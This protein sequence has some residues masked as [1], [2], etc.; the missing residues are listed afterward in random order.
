VL[1]GWVRYSDVS[2]HIS[3][4]KQQIYYMI[5]PE[6]MYY[7]QNFLAIGQ[8]MLVLNQIEKYPYVSVDSFDIGPCL[9]LLGQYFMRQCLI[10]W[11]G[12]LIY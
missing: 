3:L 4:V 11:V 1:Y 8:H 2:F 6:G 5:T 7:I 12:G 10:F 9:K